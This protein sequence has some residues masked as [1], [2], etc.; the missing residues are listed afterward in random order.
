MNHR[1]ILEPYKGRASRHPCPNCNH[2]RDTFKRYID[3]QTGQHLA[4]H[5]GKCDR[6]DGCG[7]HYPPR[8][9]FAATPGARPVSSFSQAAPAKRFDTLPRRYVD[10]ST[11]AYQCNNFVQFLTKCFGDNTA[12]RL[13]ELYKIGTSKHWPGATIFWQIDADDR[14][15]TGKIMLYNRTDGHRVKQPFNHITWAH[16]LLMRSANCQMRNEELKKTSAIGISTSDFKLQQ[17]F[18]GE[19]L[20]LTDPFKTV[21]IAESEKTAVICSFFYPKYI[22]LAAGSLEGLSWDK[23]KVLK[24]RNVKL[25]PDVNGYDKWRQK[26]REMNLRLPAARFSVDDTLEQVA[27]DDERE[28]GIDIAD[29]WIEQLTNKT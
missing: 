28:R 26:A 4:D 17:C 6:V 20:L 25:Y 21:A 15:R 16:T 13:A 12:L 29:R 5:V 8:E 19:H 11:R 10:E 2:R 22:W 7:Y 27:T 24:D 18:F 3:T 1:Y 14:V 9:Y 23:C